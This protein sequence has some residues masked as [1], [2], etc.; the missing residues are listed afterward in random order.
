MPDS[1]EPYDDMP[2]HDDHVPQDLF[3][4]FI[5]RMPQVCVEIIL[6]TREGYLLAKRDITPPGWFW[7]GSRLY[8][9]EKLTD[10]AHRIAAEELG[11]KV[12]IQDRYG[13]YAHFW[14]TSSIE[15][16]PSRHTVNTVLHVTPARDEYE[17]HLDDQHTDYRFV[18]ALEPDMHPY[19]RQYLE[20]N[21]LV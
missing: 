14:Q 16:S 20:S 9:G 8:K 19:V 5:E 6:E 12:T 21:D 2:V 15:G 10:A 17:I 11:I 7:P 13:P 1:F 4:E 3:A 18:T